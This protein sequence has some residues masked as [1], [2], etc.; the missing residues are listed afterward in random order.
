MVVAMLIATELDLPLSK[1]RVTLADARPKRLTGKL[2]G[3][4]NT[5]RSVYE[6]VRQAAAMRGSI[7]AVLAGSILGTCQVPRW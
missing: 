2:T 4:S 1:V 3:G 5:I 6:L 7:A